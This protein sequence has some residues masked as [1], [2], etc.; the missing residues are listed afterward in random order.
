MIQRPFSTPHFL[1]LNSTKCPEP[2]APSIQS[3]RLHLLVKATVLANV[4]RMFDNSIMA[5]ANFKVP[6]PFIC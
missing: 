1:Y 4:R 5:M 2:G 6:S 3:K